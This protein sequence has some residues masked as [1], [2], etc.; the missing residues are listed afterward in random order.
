MS[1]DA[2]ESEGVDWA[3]YGYVEASDH[4][5]RVVDALHSEGPATPTT[6]SERTGLDVTHVSRTLRDLSEESIVELLVPEERTKGRIYGLTDAG[7]AV[8][9]EVAA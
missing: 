8:A 5:T 1:A 6:L 7:E 2:S 3:Q 4:R 9:V